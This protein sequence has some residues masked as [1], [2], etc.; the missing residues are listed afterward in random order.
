MV[1]VKIC[2]LT[3]LTDALAAV[4]AGAHALGFVFYR[5][6]P[7]YIEPHLAKEIVA[8]LPPLV[9]TVGVFVDEPPEMIKKI[10]E[11]VGLDLVQLHGQEPP[12]VCEI[13][14][15]RVIKAF[16]ISGPQDLAR[17][18]LYRN[19]VR[20]ILLDSYRPGVPGGTGESFDWQW[21]ISAK[22]LGLPVI[23]AGGL[24][25]ENILEAIKVVEPYG[26]DVSSGVEI[27]PGEK[28]PLRIKDL[29]AKIKGLRP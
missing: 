28:D 29:I 8:S 2:G 23:L 14:F 21:A 19:V 1:R 6:S 13:L 7:R 24:R 5:R 26:V 18:D 25:P 12:S 4:A 17:I 15:P 9:T 3:R 27:S 20:A 16:R 10:M 11:E 22:A